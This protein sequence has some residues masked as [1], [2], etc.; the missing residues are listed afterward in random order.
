MAY[1]FSQQTATVKRVTPNRNIRT[2]TP[3]RLYVARPTPTDT[4]FIELTAQNFRHT[5]NQDQAHYAILEHLLKTSYA[6]PMASDPFLIAYKLLRDS[7]KLYGTDRRPTITSLYTSH[8]A[9]A[10]SATNGVSFIHD[11]IQINAND[12][13][14]NGWTNIN[15]TILTS[16]FGV[17]FDALVNSINRRLV[18]LNVANSIKFL[19]QMAHRDAI[20]L[21][22]RDSMLAGELSGVKITSNVINSSGELQGIFA[23]DGLFR[24]IT[25]T[26]NRVNV[27]GTHSI[28]INGLLSG[29]I[30]SNVTNKPIKLLPLRIGGSANIYVVGFKAGT[31]YA[32]DAKKLNIDDQRRVAQSGYNY[33]NVDIPLFR[34]LLPRNQQGQLKPLKLI[35][36]VAI[37]KRCGT[38][39]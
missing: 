1:S 25:I 3:P 20:Q 16:P 23:S 37:M 15:D 11:L 35:E 14:V 29:S 24:N 10:L 19:R 4:R 27:G 22:P 34:R 5:K 12:V 36:L 2:A 31:G 21:I 26:G 9:G 32:Y 18:E 38:P 8:T 33:T 30:S 39:A 28:T 7:F 17:A 6:Q 13:I